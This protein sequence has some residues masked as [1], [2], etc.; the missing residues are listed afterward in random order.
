MVYFSNSPSEQAWCDK[1]LSPDTE[2]MTA[3]VLQAVTLRFCVPSEHGVTRW[4]VSVDTVPGD[5]VLQCWRETLCCY[6]EG[7]LAASSNLRSKL[8]QEP[9]SSGKTIHTAKAQLDAVMS[10]DVEGCTDV[11]STDFLPIRNFWSHHLNS[12]NEMLFPF[13]TPSWHIF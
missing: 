8:K 11:V 10:C 5:F 6:C 13:C 4:Y 9:R 2:K 7:N 3:I 1:C 12:F